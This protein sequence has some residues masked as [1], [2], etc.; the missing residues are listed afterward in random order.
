MKIIKPYFQILS[1][2]E[3]SYIYKKLLEEF[4]QSIMKIFNDINV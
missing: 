4:K 3:V 1:L 2:Q